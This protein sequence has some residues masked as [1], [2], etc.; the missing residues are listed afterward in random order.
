MVV[1]WGDERD[2]ATGAREIVIRAKEATEGIPSETRQALEDGTNGFERI[3][4]GPNRMYP[5]T[6][7]PPKRVTGERLA[8]IQARI[9]EPYWEREAWYEKLGVPADCV[10]PLAI[11]LNAPTFKKAVKSWKVNPKLAAVSIIQFPKR[12]KHKGFTAAIAPD[13]MEAI[14]DA[15]R[16]GSVAQEGILSVMAKTSESGKF[17]AS[18]LPVPAEAD[19]VTEIADKACAEAMTL[20]ELQGPRRRIAMRIAMAT[21]RGRYPGIKLAK[22]VEARLQGLN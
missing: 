11:S 22:M 15:Y 7:L 17:D 2:A 20:S 18:F 8:A 10:R 1:V 4:P 13:D 6:D 3:L 5:D 21:L 16:K 19:A 14:F 9:P 12:L